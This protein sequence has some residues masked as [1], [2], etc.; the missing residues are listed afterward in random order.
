VSTRNDA[1]VSLDRAEV[2]ER[3][4]GDEAFLAELLALYDGEFAEK[5]TALAAAIETGDMAAVRSLG[6]SLKG[7]SANL[8]LPGLREAA[9]EME[10]AGGDKNPAAARKALE[11]LADEYRALKAFLG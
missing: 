9:Q 5:S 7:S 8:S 3:I 4:G 2:L 1:R 10:T 6:H 11:R